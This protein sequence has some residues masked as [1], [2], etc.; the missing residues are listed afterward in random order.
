MKQTVDRNYHINDPQFLTLWKSVAQWYVCELPQIG[1]NKIHF[2]EYG[3]AQHRGRGLFLC[4][5]VVTEVALIKGEPERLHVRLTNL[6]DP[7]TLHLFPKTSVV[8]RSSQNCITIPIFRGRMMEYCADRVSA[9]FFYFLHRPEEVS[10]WIEIIRPMFSDRCD[11]SYGG[12]FNISALEKMLADK[13]IETK[14]IETMGAEREHV[15][16][17][18]VRNMRYSAFR[19]HS[20]LILPAEI[21][22]RHIRKAGAE[23]LRFTKHALAVKR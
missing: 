7:L 16:I 19:H 8:C 9:E 18:A 13:S 4:G 14:S 6:A 15:V 3:N 17:R 1:D 20:P 22:P 2:F 21:L 10:I 5:G 23:L 12:C 11:E